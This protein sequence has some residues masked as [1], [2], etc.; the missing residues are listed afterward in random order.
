[1]IMCI[2]AMSD[3]NNILNDFGGNYSI[4]LQIYLKLTMTVLFQKI[5]K[6]SIYLTINVPYELCSTASD[7]KLKSVLTQ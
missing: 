2:M 1:M 5:I 3:I 7:S 6:C 4:L